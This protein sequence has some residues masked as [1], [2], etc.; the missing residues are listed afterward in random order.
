[1]IRVPAVLAL[2]TCAVHAQIPAFPGAEG[3]GAYA[4]GGRGGDVYVVTNLN[5]SGPGS[6]YEG[7]TTVPTNG[8][9]VV[10]A[11][12]G[13]IRLAS[14]VGTRI[15]A[16]KLT[17]AGQTAPGDGILL[18]DGTCASP[19]MTW[20][21]ATSVSAMARTAPEAIAS[22]SIPDARTPSSTSVDVVQYR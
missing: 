5:S 1:M 3:F 20:S 18:K 4:N 11:V 22:I 13:Q 16:N 17:I 15:T 19:A 21:S 8:R 10:F 2:L 9:T 7:I 14:G 12:S 6:F